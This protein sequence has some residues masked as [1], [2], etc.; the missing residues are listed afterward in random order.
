M[1][2]TEIDDAY[3][4]NWLLAAFMS[5]WHE[6]NV[7]IL[8]WSTDPVFLKGQR[9]NLAALFL[10]S[11]RTLGTLRYFWD[12][13]G[14]SNCPHRH[15]HGNIKMKVVFFDGN[16]INEK[17]RDFLKFSEGFCRNCSILSSAVQRTCNSYH[18][19][20]FMLNKNNP[21]MR[22]MWKTIPELSFFM[23]WGEF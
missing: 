10:V 12:F 11:W 13:E 14:T 23:N 15:S 4:R 7:S 3:V 6:E 18:F 17:I 20:T 5:S 16:E 22:K 21:I 19:L 2:T 1:S 9:S 8:V